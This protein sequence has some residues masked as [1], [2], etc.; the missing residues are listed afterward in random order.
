MLITFESGECG[1]KDTQIPMLAKRLENNRRSVNADYW[2]PG[3]TLKAEVIRL[4]LKN[5]YDSNFQFPGNF[6]KT[7]DLEK[8]KACFE[9]ETV[10]EIAAK[11]LNEAMKGLGSGIKYET[12]YF[13][14]NNNFMVHGYLAHTINYLNN[15]EMHRKTKKPNATPAELLFRNFFSEE[16]LGAGVQMYLYMAA[17]NIIYDGPVKQ[18]LNDYDDVILNRSR[19]SSKVYQGHAQNPS[20]NNKIDELNNEA[21]R[22][23]VP[24]LT[25]LLDI[26]IEELARRKALRAGTAKYSGITKDFFDEKEESFHIKVR[27]GYLD[28]A[29]RCASLP[30]NHKEYN[31]IKIVDG[32][33][34]PEEVHERIWTIVLDYIKKAA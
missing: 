25:I 6:I 34:T 10:P 28:E 18:A 19:D 4:L 12:I 7:F 17:R 9:E 31:R 24:D 1:G 5:K 13:L 27:Q 2:E 15:E 33:G 29:A 16:K 8:Y 23:I 11:Y 22:G 26:S 30:K 20:L 32:K 14:L 3:S 21:T